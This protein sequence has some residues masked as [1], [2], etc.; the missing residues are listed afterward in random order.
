MTAL[1]LKSSFPRKRESTKAEAAGDITCK[2]ESI[3]F[4][5]KYPM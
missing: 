3:A 1:T 5:M 4:V 2:R